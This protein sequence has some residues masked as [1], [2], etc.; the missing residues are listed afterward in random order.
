MLIDLGRLADRLSAVVMEG[1]RDPNAICE[2]GRLHPVAVAAAVVVLAVLV[3]AF[4]TTIALV[5]DHLA[6][7][8]LAF[9][10]ARF[11]RP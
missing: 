7:R 2:E 5:L 6:D 10:L 11:G 9:S 1:P 3:V 4:A 8:A